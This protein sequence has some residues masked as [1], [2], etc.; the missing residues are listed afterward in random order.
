MEAAAEM[1]AGC[2]R[3]GPPHERLRLP[4]GQAVAATRP[5]R[6]LQPALTT[7]ALLLALTMAEASLMS[8]IGLRLGAKHAQQSRLDHRP[9]VPWAVRNIREEAAASERKPW[10][11]VARRSKLVT[12]ARRL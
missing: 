11:E 3:T 1:S 5:H 9:R 6:M 2:A 7:L 4:A 10:Q 8:R 12:R